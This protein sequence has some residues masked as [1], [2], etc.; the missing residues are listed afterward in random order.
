MIFWTIIF[1]AINFYGM[2]KGSIFYST[3]QKLELI[4]IREAQGED[5]DKINL[6]FAK[7]GCLPLLIVFSL[8][9]IEIIYLVNA[10]NYD[11]YKY[12]SIFIIV[13]LIAS[14]VL[15]KKKNNYKNMNEEE[16]SKAKDSI[17]K[18]DKFSLKR[19]FKNFLWVAY[20]GYMFYC[21]VF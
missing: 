7:K 6:E 16:L 15:N 1:F 10:I 5:K 3:Y 12:P 21:L 4:S 11:I 8:A 14:F 2:I 18:G 20:F 13:Y 19:F 9:V 17:L